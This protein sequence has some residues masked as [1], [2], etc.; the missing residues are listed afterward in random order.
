MML[1]R[2][3]RD[4]DPMDRRLFYVQSLLEKYRIGKTALL[5]ALSRKGRSLPAAAVVA[6]YW[7]VK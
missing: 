2:N 6:T 1:V 3:G 4:L 7:Q 5:K